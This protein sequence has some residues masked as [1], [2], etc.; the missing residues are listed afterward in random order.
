MNFSA[1]SLVV[2]VCRTEVEKTPK[3]VFPH[4]V[5]VLKALHGESRIELTDAASPLGTVELDAEAEFQ[6][7]INEYAPKGDKPHPV[8]EVYRSYDDF[9]EAVTAESK[10]RKAK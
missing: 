6:R 8:T 2:L 3:I 1:K 5:D 9:L 7:L 10:P 4:E